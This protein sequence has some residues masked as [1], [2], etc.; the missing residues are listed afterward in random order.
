MDARDT[1]PMPDPSRE[2]RRAVHALRDLEES[3]RLRQLGAIVVHDLNNAMFALGGRLQLLRRT[4]APAH[5]GAVDGALDSMRLLEAQL[6]ALRAACPRDEPGETGCSVR[7]AIAAALVAAAAALPEEVE[8][9]GI[10]EAI[11]RIDAR[12]AVD[13]AAEELA[14]AIRQLVSLH[15]ARGARKIAVTVEDVRSARGAPLVRLSL[16]DHAGAPAERPTIPSLLGGSFRLSDL[17]LA[18]AHRATREFG[19]KVE[20]EATERG[21]RTSLSFEVRTASAD[22]IEPGESPA[23][24][25]GLASKGPS[26]TRPLRIL[27]ADDDAAV[28]AVLVAALEAG[29]HDVESIAR[30]ADIAARS[31][32]SE[33]DAVIVDAGGGGLEAL[34]AVRGRGADVPALVAS[35]EFVA[36]PKDPWT[37]FVLKP[38]GLDTLETTLRAL[39]ATRPRG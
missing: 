37:R 19:G 20:A 9:A 14:S 13:A 39:S 33:F 36:T 28:R 17:P 11:A 23:A 2:P 38:F 3:D 35:G 18:A 16:E 30:P 31:D 1:Q 8:L 4:I 29:D 5:A 7:E 22:A 34:H 21:I 12:L 26:A 6:A 15:R 25:T 32:L 24:E 10:A 27:I